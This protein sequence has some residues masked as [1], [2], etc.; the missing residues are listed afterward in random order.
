MVSLKDAAT[1]Q[2]EGGTTPTVEVGHALSGAGAEKDHASGGV[3]KAEIA[4]NDGERSYSSSFVDTL[5][6]KF[7]KTPPGA[8]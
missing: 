2:T 3:M 7:V 6:K 4:T 5:K 1:R 8:K